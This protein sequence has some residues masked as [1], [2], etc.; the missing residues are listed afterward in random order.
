[1]RLELQRSDIRIGDSTQA[2][3]SGGLA[4]LSEA[5]LLLTVDKIYDVFDER[6]LKITPAYVRKLIHSIIEIKKDFSLAYL[7]DPS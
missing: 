6:S 5:N 1:M 4:C 2:S 7:D 3:Q